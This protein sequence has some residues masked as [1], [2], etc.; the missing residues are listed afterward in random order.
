[1]PA[2]ATN[3]SAAGV[4]LVIG[5][6]VC[7]GTLG[8]F[9]KL[10]YRLGLTTPQL[11]SYRFALAAVLLWLVITV[12]RQPLPPRR[13]LLGLAIMGG[14]GYVGQSASYFSALHYIPAST[15]ALLLYTYPVV[16]TLLAA[17]LFGEPLG[18]MKFGAAGLAFLGTL[19][20]VEA[21]VRAVAPIG[22]LL[23]LGS[24]AFYTGY[25]LYGSRLL[26]S[27]PPLAATA[28]IMTAAAAVWSTFA[29]ASGQAAVDWTPPR[30][31][32]IAAFAV[33]GTTIPI[34]TFILGLRLIGP[35]RAAILSTF[36]PASTIPL[37]VII[38]GET[39]SGLQVLGGALIL[40]S[41][42]ALEGPGWRASRVLAQAA[43]E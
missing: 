6:A 34:L 23:G 9:G 5:S 26:P 20:V 1:M 36:E 37:A 28:A 42:L 33:V 15:N 3:R 16:V 31:A 17:F 35:S 43:R 14:A 40:L 12:A 39:T 13:S 38:L 8:I 32:L 10:A 22:I 30:L 18:W 19:L 11:L 41:V 27:L 21:Q 29:A 4:A 24:A 7:F 2:S 25:I